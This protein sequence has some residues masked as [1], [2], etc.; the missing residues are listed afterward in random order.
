MLESDLHQ[1]ICDTLVFLKDPLQPKQTLFSSAEEVE[2]FRVK[3]ARQ[4]PAANVPVRAPVSQKPVHK[5]V[6]EP[7]RQPIAKK[8]LLEPVVAEEKPSPPPVKTE[9]TATTPFAQIKTSLQRIAPH[10]SLIDEVPDDMVAKKVASS[11]KEKI[12]DVDV[13]LLACHMDSETLEFLKNLGKAIDTH[14]AKA[15]IIPADKLEKEGRWDVFLQKNSFRLIVA[16]HGMQ[17]LRGLMSFYHAIPSQSQLFLDKIP[18]LALS[19]AAVYKSIDHKA[20]L[21]K[22][23]CQLLK[24]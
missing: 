15:K 1:L 19:E 14:L 9:R 20:S 17:E 11:W 22:T 6:Q 12:P 23:L 10:L 3:T 7:I 18:L 5:P 2:F 13:V 4:I 21:W 8:P 24:K 16:S